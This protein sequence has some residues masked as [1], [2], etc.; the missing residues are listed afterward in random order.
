MAVKNLAYSWEKITAAQISQN[1]TNYYQ[2]N[3]SGSNGL[4]TP[5][6][7]AWL[8]IKAISK[9]LNGQKHEQHEAE[10]QNAGCTENEAEHGRLPGKCDLKFDRKCSTRSMRR[11]FAA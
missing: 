3:F 7:F 4:N 10:Q 11:R 9:Q 5:V 2:L 8:S 1:Y 6:I